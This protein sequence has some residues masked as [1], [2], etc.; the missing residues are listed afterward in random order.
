MKCLRPGC[1]HMA[2]VHELVCGTQSVR[3]DGSIV[4]TEG[5]YEACRVRGCKCDR[6]HRKHSLI[7]TTLPASGTVVTVCRGCAY[8]RVRVP[9]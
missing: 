9:A 2:D 7:D 5:I 4:Q 8:E 6:L 3:P 1:S